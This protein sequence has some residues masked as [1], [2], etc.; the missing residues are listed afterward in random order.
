MKEYLFNKDKTENSGSVIVLGG[1][2]SVHRGHRALIARGYAVAKKLNLP[3]L[4]FTFD[5]DL[6]AVSP[7]KKGLV[8]TYEER[9]DI[10]SE[11]GVNGVIRAHFNEKF[12]KIAPNEFLNIL[13][14]DF[15]P[16]AVLCGK[17]YSFGY[18]AAGKADTAKEFFVRRGSTF[19][20][21]DFLSSA[22]EKI[23][24]RRIKEEL[25]KGDVKKANFLLGEEYF[26]K[27]K[28][29]HGREEGRKIGFPTAN[30]LLNEQKFPLKHGVYSTKADING[31][32]YRGIT[33]FGFAPTFGFEK[34]IIETYFAGFSG[35]VYGEE[36]TLKFCDFLRDDRKFSSVDELK[37][38]L[39]SDLK[40]IER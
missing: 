9:L 13:N 24:T 23:S 3:L 10:F 21:V 17:D 34:L 18:K 39:K 12:A 29:V 28:V 31:K 2:D 26:I 1:F 11:C 16:K 19:E 36:I 30:M 8:F 27:E 32:T 37:A 14:R 15:T 22:G 20:A 7:V 33:N 4:V 25:L 6:S 5:G 35:D 38:Q 40:K